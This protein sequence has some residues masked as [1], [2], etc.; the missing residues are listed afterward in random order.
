[1]QPLNHTCV[2]VAFW[3]L[4]MHILRGPG[5]WPCGL[6]SF[7]L[8]RSECIYRCAMQLKH[9]LLL[10]VCDLHRSTKQPL[11]ARI[12]RQREFYTAG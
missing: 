4:A 5:V 2:V 11:A 8:P 12:G 7:C 10:F 1:M 9:L 3:Q 6:L